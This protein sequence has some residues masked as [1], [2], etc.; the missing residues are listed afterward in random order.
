[1]EGNQK[2][3]V[4]TRASKIHRRNIDSRDVARYYIVC[5]LPRIFKNIS[6]T[7]L[8]QIE[9]SISRLNEDELWSLLE[10]MA[11]TYRANSVFHAVSDIGLDW[12]EV[13]IA[14][15]EITLGGVNPYV[16]KVTFS[17]EIKRS[18]PEFADYLRRYFNQ[19]TSD[20]PLKLKEFSPKVSIRHPR[21]ILWERTGRIVTLDGIHRLISQV[22]SGQQTVRAYLAVHNNNQH[23][24]MLGKS[25]FILMRT[26]YDKNKE[27]TQREHILDVTRLMALDSTDGYRSIKEHWI[28]VA[29]TLEIQAAGED[30]LKRIKE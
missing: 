30:L 10:A 19:H 27:P 28:D 2:I 25:I 18:P 26:L 22:L 29:P 7:A 15:N 12:Y 24:T 20:D 5:E 16:N 14:V 21:I 13:E 11:F 23:K 9:A 6:E 17:E 4:L 1:M 3:T 8:E